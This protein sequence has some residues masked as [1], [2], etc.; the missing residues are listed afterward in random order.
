[1]PTP[2]LPPVPYPRNEQEARTV[3]VIYAVV[4]GSYLVGLTVQ[5]IRGGDFRFMMALLRYLRWRRQM[6]KWEREWNGE[7]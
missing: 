1:M 5:S 4:W 7:R 2:E 6:R 3:A